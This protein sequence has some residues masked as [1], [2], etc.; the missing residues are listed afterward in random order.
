MSKSGISIT[1]VVPIILEGI[2]KHDYQ[3]K[4]KKI[5]LNTLTYEDIRM[6]Q[7]E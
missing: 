3:V 4:N 5:L 6:T 1:G 2:Y 7:S